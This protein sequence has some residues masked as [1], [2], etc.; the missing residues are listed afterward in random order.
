M[1]HA[2]TAVALLA[3]LAAGP[4]SAKVS[5]QEAARLGQDLTPNGAE[6]AG[7][8]E[9]TLPAWTG[10][11]TK[12]PACYKKGERYCDP[13]ADEK[14]LYTITPANVKQYEKFLSPGQR[15]MFAKHAT[16]KM[17]VYQSHRTLALPAHV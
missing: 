4:V 12:P 15:A 17:N 13:F 14:P 16:Y 2:L 1:R 7:N 3:L 5:A 8:K 6:K 10:G 9:G 11:L